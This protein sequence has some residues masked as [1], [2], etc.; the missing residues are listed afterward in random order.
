MFDTNVGVNWHLKFRLK[1]EELLKENEEIKLKNKILERKIK[2]YEN[3]N[4][5]PAGNR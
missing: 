4:I 1:I 2:K 5:R 3:N